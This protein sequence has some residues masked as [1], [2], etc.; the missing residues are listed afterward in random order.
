MLVPVSLCKSAATKVADELAV[1][2]KKNYDLY[3]SFED[4]FIK[5][6]SDLTAVSAVLHDAEKKQHEEKRDSV[7][8]WL[9]KLQHALHDAEDLLDDIKAESLR[10]NV[11][12]EWRVVTWVRNFYFLSSMD[13]R[14]KKIRGRIEDIARQRS[15]LHLQELNRGDMVVVVNSIARQRKHTTTTTRPYSYPRFTEVVGREQD[16]R[17][18]MERLFGGGDDDGSVFVVPVVGI[19][20]LGKT[21]LVHLVFDDERV[22]RGF[23]LRIWVDVSDDLN[24]ERV[25]QK[26][27]VRAVNCGDDRNARGIDSVSCLEDRVRGKRFLLVL[28]DVWNCNRVEWLD[29]KKLL[30]NGER[31]S[32]ILV[33]TRYKITASIMGGESSLYQLGALADGDCWA[34]FEKWAFGEGES[35]QHHPNLVRIGEEIVT[36]CGGVPLAIRTVGGI[37]SGSKE[38]SYWLSVKNSDTWGMDNKYTMGL[39][40]MSEREDGILSVLKLS[41]DQLPT[42][43]KECFA[44]CSLLSKGREFDKQDLIHSW[45]AQGFIHHASGQQLEDVGSWY[46]N[47]FVSRSIFEVVRENHKTEITKCR[48]HD[49]LHDLAKLVAGSLMVNS[50]DTA[51]MSESTRHVSFWGHDLV[52][53]DP[54]SF[55]NLPK[56]RT[57]VLRT[58]NKLGN[59]SSGSGE[60]H[61]H[62]LLSGS[63]YLRVLDLSYS[64]LK[65]L[66]NS[67]GNLKHLRYC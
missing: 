62:A 31:G 51:N 34:L 35:A 19:G 13:Y 61:L 6:Q 11:E 54:R 55:L 37:L 9:R 57:L 42:P 47:E 29:V 52:T 41:Y 60:S 44:Y 26:K 8:D 14:V 21:A 40:N 53:E 28:D 48:M 10:Q 3:S 24:P 4:D 50:G 36:K 23:D 66:P 15:S 30:G 67:I 64:G 16:K 25:R 58:N 27:V 32:R 45:M 22:K 56:L 63:T 49:L 39:N 5:L 43:L 65:Q 33:T 38:E 20:G 46:V 7:E 2:L 1:L 17:S 12:A 59:Y 18:V